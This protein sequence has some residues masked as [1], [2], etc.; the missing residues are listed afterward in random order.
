MTLEEEVQIRLKKVIENCWFHGDGWGREE[1]RIRKE[2]M[3]KS[4]EKILEVRSFDGMR[5]AEVW[6]DHLGWKVL[7][8]EHEKL[9]HTT[10]TGGVLR[11]AEILA[12]DFTYGRSNPELLLEEGE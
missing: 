11:Q 1:N 6:Q 10:K 4:M 9:V 8:F 3:E 7:F 5:R 12:E 2:L